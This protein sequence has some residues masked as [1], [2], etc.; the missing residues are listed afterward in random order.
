[1]APP[2]YS[3][4][5]DTA[6][7]VEAREAYGQALRLLDESV[8]RL[9]PE[10]GRTLLGLARVAPGGADRRLV[11]EALEALKAGLGE[12][13]PDVRAAKEELRAGAG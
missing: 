3:P 1:M 5:A 12:E 2:R 11:Q 10:A 9:H 8:G 6:S 4:L 7:K 13:H